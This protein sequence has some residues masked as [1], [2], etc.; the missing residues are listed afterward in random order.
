MIR[1]IRF[2]AGDE[3][4]A[5]LLAVTLLLQDA[6]RRHR[7]L[8]L[9]VPR[10]LHDTMPSSA[11][12]QILRDTLSAQYPDLETRLILRVWGQDGFELRSLPQGEPH[13]AA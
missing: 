5:Q 1:L 11:Y 9:S 13:E 3:A 12:P 7:R 6:L 2:A 10:R 4:Q 8:Q